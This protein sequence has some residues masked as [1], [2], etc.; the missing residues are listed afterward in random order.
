M[1]ELSYPWHVEAALDI[2][3]HSATA[4]AA[5]LTIAEL[6]FENRSLRSRHTHAFPSSALRWAG[7]MCSLQSKLGINYQA[8]N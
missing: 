2:S 6:H 7:S 3:I 1:A 8:Y 4:G 5:L